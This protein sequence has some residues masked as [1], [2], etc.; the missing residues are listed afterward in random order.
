[1]SGVVEAEWRMAAAGEP[2][3]ETEGHVTQREEEEMDGGRKH[4][5]GATFEPEGEEVHS[6]SSNRGRSQLNLQMFKES[7]GCQ[8][9]R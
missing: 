1:M 6:A 9:L 8:H 2:E 4:S 7:R 5:L 3:E